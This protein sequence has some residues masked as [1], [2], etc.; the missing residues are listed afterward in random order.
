MYNYNELRILI[1]SKY[2]TLGNFCNKTGL[3]SVSYLSRLLHN[4]N[5]FTFKQ[6]SAISSILGIKKKDIGRYFFTEEV[7]K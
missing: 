7:S 3:F 6:M 5:Y 2:G 4:E 1:L